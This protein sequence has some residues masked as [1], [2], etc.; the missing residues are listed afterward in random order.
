MRGL[1]G[2]MFVVALGALPLL[3]CG[4]TAAGCEGAINGTACD[5]GACMDG[6]CTAL[7]TVSGAVIVDEVEAADGATVSWLGSTLS[8]TTDE[9][10]A[11]SFEVPVGNLFLQASKAGTWGEIRLELTPGASELGFD[12]TSD[13]VVAQDWQDWFGVDADTTKGVVEVAFFEFSGLGG[14]G[15]TLS[16]RY[17]SSW[18][19]NA[20]NTLVMSNELLRGGGDGIVFV[21]VDPTEE[22]T[23]MPSGAEGVNTCGLQVP[24]TLYPVVA[25]F[26]TSVLATCTP[27]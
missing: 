27:L 24:G 7:T 4:E 22:A 25:K 2:L 18:A 6:V 1:V 14:E 8:T 23:V 26:H 21:N 20:N 10:G 12:L 13:A 17:H 9:S 11:F 15:A 3:G 5:D 19:G 16:A